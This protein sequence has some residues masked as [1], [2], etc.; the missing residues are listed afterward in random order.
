M[1]RLTQYQTFMAI[2]DAGSLSG[3]ARALNITPSAVSKQIGLLE[4]H[5]GTR[6]LD[7]SNRQVSA[8]AAGSLFYQECREILQ[9]VTKA[10]NR[11]RESQ[12]AV[13]GRISITISKSL[14]RTSLFDDLA[15]FADLHPNIRF[16]IHM[17]DD[18]QDLQQ[19]EH[20]FAFRLG[21]TGD[22]SRLYGRELAR[23]R[24]ACLASPSYLDRWGAPA[25]LQDL[26]DHRLMLLMPRNLSEQ[27][28]RFLRD[29]KVV[30][31]QQSH[32]I[33]DDVE[34]VFQSV[35]SGMALGLMLDLTV[36]KEVE[37]GE[38]IPLLENAD[39]PVK[40]LY[41][42]HQN[43]DLAPAK[44]RVF[45]DFILQQWQNRHS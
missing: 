34:S 26:N 43:L 9:H 24:L 16:D 20:D 39:L 17:S 7:R 6:L 8:T 33:C 29:E 42:L 28:R 30:L 18:L 45:R 21:A 23:C 40:S 2:L 37:S 3:A 25:Q 41:L 22:S 35:R 31:D 19:G 10:E 1:S 38:F 32:D 4:A 13:S 5:L 11:I 44:N 27:L 36:A 12:D 15:A 14:A